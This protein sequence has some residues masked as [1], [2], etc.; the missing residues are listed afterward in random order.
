MKKKIIYLSAILV[1]VI[2][3]IT[4]SC[5]YKSKDNKY[6]KEYNTISKGMAIMIKE[7][8]AT[9]YVQSNSKDIPKGNYVLN[10]DK[11]YCKNNGKIGN[12]DS[13]LGKIS[14]SFIGTDSCYLYFDY[15]KETIKLGN[16]ELV[17]NGGTPD[18]SKVATTNEGLFKADDDYTATTGM[19]SY[20][21]R[22]AVDN[23]WVKFGKDSTGKD[24]YWRIIRI[25][26]DGSIRMIYSGTTAP[27]E[28][29]KVVMT[30]TGTQI[31]TSEFNS[32]T[33][34]AEYVGYMYTSG[35]QY[36][37]ST[38]STIKTTID[39]WYAG[40]TLK[41][42]PLVSKDQ[43]FCNDRSPS[44][45]Q[46]AAWTSTGWYSYGAYGR[47]VSNK[48]PTLKCPTASDKFTVNV[49]KGNGSLT[50]P[51]GLITADEIAMA[52]GVNGS[53][54]SSYYLYTN[55]NYW[56]GP[57]YF[58]GSTTR[59]FEFYVGY[60]GGI[61]SYIVGSDY[62]AR[63][64]ISLSSKAKLSGD[65]TWNNVFEVEQKGYETILA[66]NTV[67]ETTPDFSKVTTASEK[68]LYAADDDY[69]ATTGMKSYYFRGAVD[70][71]WVKF[72]KDST[73][74]DIYWR[75]IRINGDGSIRMIYTGTTA[76]TSSTA[77]VMTGDG[78]QISTSK[79]NGSYNNPIY[80]GY[81][82]TLDEQHGNSTTSTIKTTI[83]NW[84]KMTTLKDNDLV[85]DRLFC[86][87]RSAT[88]STSS[89][90]G[91]IG[92][93]STRSDYYYGTHIRLITNKTPLLTCPTESDKFTVNAR[94]GNGALIYPVGFITADEVAMAG[95]VYG[96]EN[97]TFYLYSNQN[98]WSMS[99]RYYYG[100]DAGAN[101][102]YINSAGNLKDS[103]VDN[104]YGVRPVVSLSSKAKLSGSGTYNDVYTVVGGNST[105]DTS[106]G[107]SFDTVFAANNT[108]I[109]SENGIRYE[110]ADPNNYICLD[111][112]TSGTCSDNSLLFRIIG[113]FDEEYSTN[114]TSSSGT[115]KLLKVI[116][117]NNYGGTSGKLWNSANTNNW[118]TASLKTELN[119][120][121]L[122]TLLGT[123]NVNSKLSSAIAN[124]KWHLGGA[125][126]TSSSNY[127]CQKITT[128]NLHKAE[129][130]PYA[131]SGTLQNLYSGNPSSIYAKVGLMYPSDY[132][133]A[134][135]GGTTTNKSSCREKELYNWDS[136]SFSDCKNNDWLY[137]S[138]VASWGSNKN[139]W[140]LSPGSSGSVNATYLGSSGYVYIYDTGV[141]GRQIAVRPAFYLDSSILKI[142]GTGDGTK[143][144]AYRLG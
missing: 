109:F 101:E 106:S 27:T 77:T 107:K 92:G 127:F 112:K 43:I 34:K 87:D 17:V 122:T 42:N 28:S 56:S 93:L 70:N 132:G 120:T 41:D 22:G 81:M 47:L 25:N 63:P 5:I 52:G 125:N 57:S 59:A 53:S 9:D 131:T 49:S 69:T 117:T 105:E 4:L 14:F 142:V 36:G 38:D 75:I 11:S 99:P 60:S 139:E 141:S 85:A 10:R 24:I 114:G 54:N 67:N 134:T 128:E 143:D 118:S 126:S 33:D 21:F 121:Y 115:K 137:T 88:K 71:N 64:V 78:T 40:T 19:K 116:D 61:N 74:K 108:D 80:V 144:N 91:E 62:G 55:Q 44:S 90:P 73:G 129:R 7:E 94:N 140:L 2:S 29:T 15:K 135:V 1:L 83:D 89:T 8:G 39:N 111:N 12:Y 32:S 45:T 6:N 48:T 37:T 97:K 31:G 23:N 136:S 35:Q 124:A 16:A 113:L 30:G 51:V 26:G 66:N 100:Y 76:P 119:G 79:L 95:G 130:S 86:N 104:S 123:S 18:F 102:F 46:T 110:G 68:G 98:Y 103:R 20:Y 65:G 82:Y 72:G 3:L 84:Y 133:Y 50:Y 58:N 96:Q 13:S 138:Q